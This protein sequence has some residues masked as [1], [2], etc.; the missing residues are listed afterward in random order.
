MP[1]KQRLP[2]PTLGPR[3]GQKSEAEAHRDEA[4]EGEDQDA[5]RGD[6]PRDPFRGRA[7]PGRDIGELGGHGAES[8]ARKARLHPQAKAVDGFGDLPRIEG[9]FGHRARA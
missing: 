4:D 9:G 5:E 2:Q 6:G 1:G 7:R 3:E 8:R